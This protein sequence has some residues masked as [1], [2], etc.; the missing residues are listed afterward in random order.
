MV[1]RS[2]AF[3]VFSLEHN[4]KAA[5]TDCAHT[6]THTKLCFTCRNIDTLTHIYT[7]ER[8]RERKRD[9]CAFYCVDDL[10]MWCVYSLHSK[11]AWNKLFVCTTQTSVIRGYTPLVNNQL[12]MCAKRRKRKQTSST[13]SKMRE[14][15]C[16]NIC[17]APRDFNMYACNNWCIYDVTSGK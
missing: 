8:E 5:S 13:S 16:V 7:A 1:L 12:F 15:T 14:I 11:N 4:N 9:H 2:Q 6:H 17:Q 3:L 10:H